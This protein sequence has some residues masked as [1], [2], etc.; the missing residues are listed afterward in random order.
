LLANTARA[1][2]RHV[3][4]RAASSL[5]RVKP[6]GCQTININARRAQNHTTPALIRHLAAATY[7]LACIAIRSAMPPFRPDSFLGPGEQEHASADRALETAP[8]A[9]F[10]SAVPTAAIH[11]GPAYVTPRKPRK[12][13][14]RQIGA[15]CKRKAPRKESRVSVAEILNFAGT[16]ASYTPLTPEAENPLG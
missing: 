16:E 10:S 2:Y 1:A 8:T 9:S 7:S 3:R 4:A 11:A 6:S 15:I 14:L 5:R 12:C 13:L